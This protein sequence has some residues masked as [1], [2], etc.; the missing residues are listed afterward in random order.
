MSYQK[1]DG[2]N[3]REIGQALGVANVLEGSVRRVGNRVLISV[4]LIDA[5]NDLHIWAERYDR[6]LA[7]SLGLQ[8]E[9]AAQIA[10]ALEAQLGPEEKT[11]LEKKPTDNPQAYALYLQA[12]GR[13][14]TLNKA[15]DYDVATEQLYAQA[16]ALD[17]K[18]ALA[19]ARRSIV[20]SRLAFDT[21]VQARKAQART[22]AEE[23]LHL[24]PSLGEAH[25]ALGLSL[26]W[27]T[28]DYAAALKE[29]SV[30]MATLPN[31]PQIL[32]Y[33]AGIYRRQGRWRESLATFERAQD[34]DPRGEIV[35]QAAY[36]SPL[37]A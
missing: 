22:D 15:R 13:D 18:F 33:V 31:E 3:M 5:R 20:N 25:T 19:Y 37:A 4:Q 23:A 14:G 32:L 21:D 6:P 12:R 17:P 28:K 16:I 26:Y 11:S 30:A 29:F 24:S 1:P 35:A 27:G 2:R 36:Q 8:G 10:A 34:L 9:L 7:D